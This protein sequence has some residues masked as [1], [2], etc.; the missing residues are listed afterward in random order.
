MK[1]ERNTGSLVFGALLVI[2]GLL[3]LADQTFR[4]AS[5]WELLWPM[6]V[7][8]AGAMFFVAMFSAGKGGASLAIP[9]SIVGGIG[10]ML[11]YQNISDHWESWSYGWTL[12]IMFVG[13]G[14]Y[15]MGW[16]EGSEQ[17]KQRG[18]RVIKTGFILFAIFGAFFEMIFTTGEP[19]GIR[20]Y[21]FP[22]LLILVG[23]YLLFGRLGLSSG[24]TS[25]TEEQPSSS[26]DTI[27]P[28][29]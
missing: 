21:V 1:N 11:L 20:G 23:A 5:G 17:N 9:G 27:P 28:V 6:I 12:I 2:C 25:K 14:I 18:W 19:A 29:S 22:V 8:A 10:L 15:L 24:R 13:I 7:I 26:N 16:Y 3:A 4:F